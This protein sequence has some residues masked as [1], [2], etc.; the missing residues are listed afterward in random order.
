MI[1]F[2]G[3]ANSIEWSCKNPNKSDDSKEFAVYNLF[4][5]IYMLEKGNKNNDINT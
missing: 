3:R 1:S 2:E 5:C 4:A